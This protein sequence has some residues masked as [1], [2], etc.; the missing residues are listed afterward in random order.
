MSTLQNNNIFYYAPANAERTDIKKSSIDVC[1]TTD[2]L[3][4]IPLKKF[5][6]YF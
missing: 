5:K 3:E 6:K 2:T 1:I 4:H